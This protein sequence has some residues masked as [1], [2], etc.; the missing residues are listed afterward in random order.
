MPS[1]AAAPSHYHQY[2]DCCLGG[3]KTTSPFDMA[4]R[5]TEWG[6]MGNLAQ[7]RPGER[8]DC[9]KMEVKS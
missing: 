1:V 6:F 8:L 2:V 4:C 5:M 3:G 9:S 7:L